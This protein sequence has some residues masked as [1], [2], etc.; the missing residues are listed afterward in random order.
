MKVVWWRERGGSRGERS[1]SLADQTAVSLDERRRDTERGR[2]AVTM[3]AEQKRND[4]NLFPPE[5][6][7]GQEKKNDE[8][9]NERICLYNVLKNKNLSKVNI[10]RE[11]IDIRR[12]RRKKRGKNRTLLELSDWERSTDCHGHVRVW[13]NSLEKKQK[14]NGDSFSFC[15]LR[16]NSTTR[17]H[18]TKLVPVWTAWEVL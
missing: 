4:W 6:K 2:I 17:E 9:A 3:G 5:T 16:L 18:V 7:G 8:E 15:P 12:R 11:F 13:H 14:M 10:K 1:P